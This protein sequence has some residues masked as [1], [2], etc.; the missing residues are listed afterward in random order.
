MSRYALRFCVGFKRFV[1][2]VSGKKASTAETFA[3]AKSYLGMPWQSWYTPKSSIFRC[4]RLASSWFVHVANLG[5]GSSG[6]KFMEGRVG[7]PTLVPCAQILVARI[8]H[9]H[10]DMPAFAPR[11][12]L[13]QYL[14]HPTFVSFSTTHSHTAA[15]WNCR[16]KARND[17]CWRHIVCRAELWPSL[18]FSSLVGQYDKASQNLLKV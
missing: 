4:V 3:S 14:L 9:M 11:S 1:K 12:T 6:R 2:G 7:Q 16:P 5:G 18:D 15:S 10:F 8:R 13:P 17:W